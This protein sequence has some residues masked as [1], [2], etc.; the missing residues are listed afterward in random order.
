MVTEH[1]SLLHKSNEV[2]TSL[3]KYD[4]MAFSSLYKLLSF[5]LFLVFI[6]GKEANTLLPPCS[7]WS[8]HFGCLCQPNFCQHY[9]EP[10]NKSKNTVICFGYLVIAL[11]L[12]MHIFL[13]QSIFTCK[14]DLWL[15][16]AVDLCL[17]SFPLWM[18]S[19]F[20]MRCQT[21]IKNSLKL[22]YLF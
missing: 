7:S 19:S 18:P 9:N 13:Q 1:N 4:F 5:I 8:Q 14:I 15:C 16:K 11:I 20:N 21:F 10:E 12:L 22:K 3:L 6:K 17:C 2:Y